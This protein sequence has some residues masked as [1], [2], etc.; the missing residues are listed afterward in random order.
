MWFGADCAADLDIGRLAEPNACYGFGAAGAH[1]KDHHFKPNTP[2]K[3]NAQS[4]NLART[5]SPPIPL[6]NMKQHEK[7]EHHTRT[8]S[9]CT[10]IRGSLNKKSQATHTLRGP[11]RVPM[12]NTASCPKAEARIWPNP[13]PASEAPEKDTRLCSTGPTQIGISQSFS[14]AGFVSLSTFQIAGSCTGHQLRRDEAL[15]ALG[16]GCDS[17]SRDSAV[18][19]PTNKLR[20]DASKVWG[21]QVRWRAGGGGGGRT[22]LRPFPP[23]TERYCEYFDQ[24][25]FFSNIRE[26]S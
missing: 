26:L 12:R 2:N 8:P 6:C 15:H 25:F 14:T 19:S 20:A 16:G 9:G 21:G 24:R 7:Q 4:L 5:L 10:A 13:F 1:L 23:K 3:A 17:S 18:I 11:D 22:L